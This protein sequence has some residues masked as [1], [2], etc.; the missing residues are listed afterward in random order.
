MDDNELASWF[1]KE[2]VRIGAL[3]W[4]GRA[5]LAH[6]QLREFWDNMGGEIAKRALDPSIPFPQ[7]AQLTAPD[8]RPGLDP[9]GSHEKGTQAPDI[10]NQASLLAC[11]RGA[12]SYGG[13]DSRGWRTCTS[14]GMIN[15]AP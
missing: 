14:C 11:S 12:H 2:T 10:H 1:A 9:P 8:M 15:I 13:V 5:S 7:G 6:A 4:A 3:L